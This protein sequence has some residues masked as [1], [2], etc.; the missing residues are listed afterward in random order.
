[1]AGDV[2]LTKAMRLCLSYYGENEHNPVR[3]DRKGGWSMLQA[4]RA[5]DRGWLTVGPGGWHILTDAGRAALTR[6]Q[7]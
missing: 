1:M 6:S 7:P 5:L 2:K 3:E 4:D